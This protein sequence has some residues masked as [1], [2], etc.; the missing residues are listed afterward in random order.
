MSRDYRAGLRGQ[1]NSSGLTGFKTSTGTRDGPT[2]NER[3]A[4]LGPKMLEGYSISRKNTLRQS[5][6]QEDSPPNGRVKKENRDP[7][8][9][10]KESAEKSALS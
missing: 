9:T 1:Q 4:L 6:P 3:K 7:V 10:K 2:G 8:A 5:L